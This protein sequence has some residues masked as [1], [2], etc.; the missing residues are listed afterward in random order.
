[1]SK[2]Y[3]RVDKQ[4]FDFSC[5]HFL[6]FADKTREPLHGHNYRCYVELEA[7]S[8]SSDDM[9]INYSKVKPL[10]KRICDELNHNTLLPLRNEDLKVW[11]E[12]TQVRARHIDGSEFSFP[13]QDCILLDDH[14][15]ST[16]CLSVH[17]S[18]RIKQELAGTE[19]AQR[20][21]VLRVGVEEAPGQ[22]SWFESRF[23][24]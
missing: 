4:Y 3:V 1:M 5:G 7:S 16:E 12:G 19:A 11:E 23:D 21:T 8:L 6:L 20:L 18:K 22:M 10:I 2:F 14:N 17:I 15:S 9:V 24:E 13:R